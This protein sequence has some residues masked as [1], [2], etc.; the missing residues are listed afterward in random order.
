[1]L[2]NHVPAFGGFSQRWGGG[3]A[4]VVREPGAHVEE[5]LD[6]ITS[7]DLRMLDRHEGARSPTSAS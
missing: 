3:V 5:F 1:M 4:S 6:R 2:P 7:P